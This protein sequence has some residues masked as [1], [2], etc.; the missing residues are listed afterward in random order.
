MPAVLQAAKAAGATWAG[1]EVLRLPLTVAPVF[2]QWLERVVPEKKD[3]IL[4][5]IRFHSRREI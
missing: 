5:R 3:K 1:T 4:G 2:Q